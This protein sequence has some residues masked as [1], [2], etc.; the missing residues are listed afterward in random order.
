MPGPIINIS[1]GRHAVIFPVY[2]DGITLQE[3]SPLRLHTGLLRWPCNNMVIIWSF[4]QNENNKVSV[5]QEA[6]VLRTDGQAQTTAH[7]PYPE[8]HPTPPHRLHAP[9]T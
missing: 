6:D 9:R 5:R 8:L 4:L 3:C 2:S 1:R 7:S